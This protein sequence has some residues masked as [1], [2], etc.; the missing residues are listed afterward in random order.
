MKIFLLLFFV[1]AVVFADSASF[2]T[3][4]KAR[5]KQT[6]EN[7]Y[8]R[9]SV[10]TSRSSL[11]KDFRSLKTIGTD[12]SGGVSE[13]TVL[14]NQTFMSGMGMVNFSEAQQMLF[15]VLQ[16]TDSVEARTVATPFGA[17]V[18]PGQIA[19][20]R[21]RYSLSKKF[22]LSLG[23]VHVDTFGYSDP[24]LSMRYATQ[25]ERWTHYGDLRLSAPVTER[26]KN[27]QLYTKATLKAGSTLRSGLF[28]WSGSLAHSRPFY[29][30]PAALDKSKGASSHAAMPG[31]MPSA[32]DLILLQKEKSRSSGSVGGVYRVGKNWRLSSS[33]NMT[34]VDT[35]KGKHL[36]FTGIKPIGAA[37][38][39]GN[40]EVGGS[41]ALNSEAAKFAA[42]SFPTNWT[43]GMNLSYSFGEAPHRL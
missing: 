1:P 43:L 9:F 27:D 34:Y 32:L 38:T 29:K 41:F 35:F 6:L 3:N 5:F 42:P 19:V 36:W 8:A 17:M 20:A 39:H 10:T 12:E 15:A 23:E 14:P 7:S 40:M 37:Y 13:K 24:F 2:P 11:G 22:S 26:S 4:L 30:D 28:A 31:P 21:Y 25:G 16:S 33:A 18:L